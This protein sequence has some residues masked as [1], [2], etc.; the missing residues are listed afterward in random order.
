MDV[1]IF[2]SVALKSVSSTI[3]RVEDFVI[4]IDSIRAHAQSYPAAFF[5]PTSETSRRRISDANVTALCQHSSDD[6]DINHFL[7]RVSC[8]AVRRLESPSNPHQ[9][10]YS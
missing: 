5:S 8:L 1:L 9:K 7:N 4:D 3:T 2:V 10:K 6:D